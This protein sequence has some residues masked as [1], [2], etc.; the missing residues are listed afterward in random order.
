[1]H[2]KVFSDWLPSYIKATRPF[3]EIFKMTGYF[4]GSPRIAGFTVII[5]NYQHTQEIIKKN[6]HILK[7]LHIEKLTNEE[8]QGIVTLNVAA[9]DAEYNFRFGSQQV[10]SQTGVLC[11]ISL[12]PSIQNDLTFSRLM[13][14]TH[15]VPHR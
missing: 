7:L 14:Y 4:L 1:M 8:R 12:K 15:V 5:F 6:S 13:T 2:S 9:Q 10:L 3:L 11:T